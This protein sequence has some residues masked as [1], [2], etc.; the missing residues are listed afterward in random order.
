MAD[1]GP[2]GRCCRQVDVHCSVWWMKD[3]LKMEATVEGERGIPCGLLM[4]KIDSTSYYVGIG[5]CLQNGLQA[6]K[7]RNKK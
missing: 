5:R 3:E 2:Y 4:A 7:D 6:G 1:G